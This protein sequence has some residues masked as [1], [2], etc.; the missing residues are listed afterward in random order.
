MV[1]KAREY[2]QGLIYCVELC[3]EDN[4][5]TRDGELF[6]AAADWID[7]HPD[8]CVVGITLE[9]NLSIDEPETTLRLF[10]EI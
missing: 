5:S 8:I 1:V 7:A 6:R 4:S 2:G 9:D 3:V 10:V